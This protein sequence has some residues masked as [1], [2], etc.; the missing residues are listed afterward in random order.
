MAT[1]K[2]SPT[3]SEIT[4]K[5]GNSVFQRMGQSLGIRNTAVRGYSFGDAAVA[6]RILFSRLAL[7]WQSLSSADR[8]TWVTYA[9]A[10]PAVNRY[11]ESINLTGYQLFIQLN[12]VR[13]LYYSPILTTCIPYYMI[14]TP[15]YSLGAISASTETWTF[16]SLAITPTNMRLLIYASELYTSACIDRNPKTKFVFAHH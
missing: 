12:M 14:D 1:I 10:Y 16:N 13:S 9:P 6:H 2:Y 8:L 7:A 11:G 15:S 5:L 3:V 4:G